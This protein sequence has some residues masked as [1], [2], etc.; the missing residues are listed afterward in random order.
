MKKN[1]LLV[2]LVYLSINVQAQNFRIQAPPGYNYIYPENSFLKGTEGS[3]YLNDWEYADILFTSS[4]EVKDLLVRYNVYSNQLLYKEK[5]QTYLMGAPDSISE[6]KFP[7]KTFIY[8]E[9]LPG[10]KTF[11]EV[12]L[13]GKVSLLTKYETEVT[14][15]NYNEALFSGNK[16]DVIFIKQKLYLQQGTSIVPITKKTILLEVLNDK[17]AEVSNLMTK[18]RLSFRK[19]QDMTKLIEYYN[20]LI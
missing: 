7:D 14:P 10:K 9:Y 16:N 13:K 18:E 1:F 19:K 12:V 15:A 11:F 5:Q 6:L 3:P 4:G 8:R 2:T 17:K 20:Q